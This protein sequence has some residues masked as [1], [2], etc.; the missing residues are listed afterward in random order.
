MGLG[1]ME[2]GSRLEVP[3]PHGSFLEDTPVHMP[4]SLL[5]GLH[6]AQGKG[7]VGSA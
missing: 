2:Q 3:G 5:G 7:W 4:G 6:S 1:V